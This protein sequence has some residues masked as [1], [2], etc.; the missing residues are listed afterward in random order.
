GCDSHLSEIVR[1]VRLLGFLFRARQRGQEEAGQNRDDGNHDQQLDQREASN[2][3]VNTAA[4]FCPAKPHEREVHQSI[5]FCRAKS[6]TEIIGARGEG[7]RGA[8]STTKS[9]GTD[10]GCVRSTSRSGTARPGVFAQLSD[11]GHPHLLRLVL[12]TQPRSGGGSKMRPKKSF[13]R[14]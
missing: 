1:A 13:T 10:R 4:C 7:A 11:F 14:A 3:S 12:R 9:T 5:I 2:R 8:S 6:S